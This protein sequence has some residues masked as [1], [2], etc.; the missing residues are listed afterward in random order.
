M[1]KRANRTHHGQESFTPLKAI[2]ADEIALVSFHP[3]AG[4]G[5]YISITVITPTV[6]SP[7]TTE[8]L[9]GR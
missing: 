2:N 7:H 8:S 5:L 1:G 4:G 6:I 3:Q 9:Y